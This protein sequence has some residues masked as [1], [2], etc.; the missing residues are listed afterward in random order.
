MTI[1]LGL[2]CLN[3]GVALGMMLSAA[4]RTQ[5]DSAAQDEIR[6]RLRA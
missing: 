6:R 4:L 1:V 2:V 3:V 5:R